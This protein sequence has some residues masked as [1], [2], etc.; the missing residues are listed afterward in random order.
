LLGH[1]ESSGGGRVLVAKK[2]HIDLAARGGSCSIF[3]GAWLCLRERFETR[4]G[5]KKDIVTGNK[6]VTN[7]QGY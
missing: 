1:A 2:N 3:P 6:K 7:F 4:L 5:E